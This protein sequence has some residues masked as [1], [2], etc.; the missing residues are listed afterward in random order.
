MKNSESVLFRAEHLV[1]TTISSI[2]LLFFS[3]NGLA[4][5]GTDPKQG[6]DH[7]SSPAQASQ[8][9]QTIEKDP[10][11]VPNSSAWY[12]QPWIWAIVAS[13]LILIIGLLFKAYG[14]RD[15]QSESGL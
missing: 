14:K 8:Y 12:V 11:L 6:P 15:V 10:N 9:L 7:T 3:I 1:L 2:V 13:L 5:T 4:Q